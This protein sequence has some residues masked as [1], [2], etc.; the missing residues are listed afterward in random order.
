MSTEQ[1]ECTVDYTFVI[2]LVMSQTIKNSDYL[3]QHFYTITKT[4]QA[5]QSPTLTILKYSDTG[6]YFFTLN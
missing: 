3:V 1:F 6:I 4:R 2:G 5:S